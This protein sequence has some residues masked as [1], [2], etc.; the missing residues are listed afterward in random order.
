MFPYIKK[1]NHKSSIAYGTEEC[2]L[3]ASG[4]LYIVYIC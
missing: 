3:T 2:D 1:L 4:L